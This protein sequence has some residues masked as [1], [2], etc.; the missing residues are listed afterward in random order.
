M[1]KLDTPAR[2]L[3]WA[4]QNKSDYPSATSAAEARGWNP[5]T[6]RTHENGQRN[7]D[8]DQAKIYGAAYRVP[9]IWLQEGGRLPGG[10][11]E[12]APA[13]TPTPSTGLTSLPAILTRGEV[14][15][16][17]WLD[18][19][20][21]LRPE[22]FE[23]YPIA[24]HPAYPAEAQY[25]LLVRGT[26]INKVAESGDVLHCLDLGIVPV[27][28]QTDD[29]VIAERRRYQAGQK[30]VTA[31]RISRR[32]R[33]VVLSPHSTDERWKPI[34]FDPAK[35]KDEEEVAIVA[36]VLAFYR[37]VRKRLTMASRS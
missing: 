2:R 34:E 26:S 11:A 10:M 21:E 22:D 36:I 32:G 9:W 17:T 24:A 28:P 14:A 25:G 19:D 20:V 31:K 5:S 3:K 4:R 29:Y 7:F 16:G 15:A 30:E 13:Y 27:E 23:Q 35:Q 33:V 12:G 1:D 8:N 6:Y 37:P 18:L